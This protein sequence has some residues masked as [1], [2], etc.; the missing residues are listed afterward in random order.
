M[1][2]NDKEINKVGYEIWLFLY[3]VVREDYSNLR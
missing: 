1:V 2:I 3:G